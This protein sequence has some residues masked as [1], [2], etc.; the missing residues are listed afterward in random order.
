[1]ARPLELD[2]ELLGKA[3]SYI[4]TCQDSIGEKVK[5]VNLPSIE[6]FAIFVGINSDTVR[7]WEKRDLTGLTE[8][9]AQLFREFSV[10]IAE[11]RNEQAK[12]LINDGL[13]G[14]YNPTIAKVL[15]TKHGYREGID[16]TTNDKDLPT[17]IA[18]VIRSNDSISE[19]KP[20]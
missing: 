13:S 11:L 4:A 2:A 15:L 12:R 18:N 1:M 6:G 5:R 9:Q 20:A 14:N 8:E 16:Q 19:N 10:L 17:P 7:V 3:K